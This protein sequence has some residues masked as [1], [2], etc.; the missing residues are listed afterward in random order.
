MTT[1]LN[2]QFVILARDMAKTDVAE[3]CLRLG[4][5]AAT[6]KKL[7]VMPLSEV[8]KM[9]NNCIQF[10]PAFDAKTLDRLASAKDAGTRSALVLVN[11]YG[12]G[13]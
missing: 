1:S 8:E 2:Q 12:S 13:H 4:L 3:T 6:C 7:V 11:R 5:D 10:R 9:P